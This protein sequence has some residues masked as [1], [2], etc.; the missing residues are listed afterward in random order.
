M[1]DTVDVRQLMPLMREFGELA[2][3]RVGVGVTPLE[4]QRYLDLKGRIGQRFS[5]RGALGLG[6]ASKRAAES[7]LTRLVVPF[8]NRAALISSVIDNI[9]PVGLLVTTPF[10]AE[11]G[12]RFL[13]KVS[14]EREG[15]A[16]EFPATVVTSI[17]QG[18]LTLSTTSM[19][20]GL[21]IERTNPVQG[22]GL[23]KIFAH[24]LDEK[25][26]WLD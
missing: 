11:V 20:M 22:A 19:G 26:G 10:A 12:T 16:A 18:A 1:P 21:K 17:S 4:F 2:R 5:S 24:E 25:L 6:G 15:E 13:L 7:S 8:P 9:K 3:R 23:S 14:L